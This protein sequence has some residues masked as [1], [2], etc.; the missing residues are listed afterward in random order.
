MTAPGS[1][2]RRKIL[3]LA[4]T[5]RAGLKP[6]PAWRKMS[7]EKQIYLHL[8]IFGDCCLFFPISVCFFLIC[9]HVSYTTNWLAP[10]YSK[11]L[12][13]L[14][15]WDRSLLTK[16]LLYFCKCLNFYSILSVD[17]HFFFLTMIISHISKNKI[18]IIL[19]YVFIFI[20]SIFDITLE[21]VFKDLR[22]YAIC[23]LVM[24]IEIIL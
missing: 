12:Q 11:H 8:K 2:S 1:R 22:N 4:S 13:R 10:A 6:L 7:S 24:H 14:I 21:N 20:L 16:W 3:A 15:D 23:N 18:S 5:L 19:N 9:W 17:I